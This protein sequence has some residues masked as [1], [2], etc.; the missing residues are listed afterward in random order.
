MLLEDPL[1]LLIAAAMVCVVL[2]LMIGVA[3]FAKGG[4][5]NRKYGNLLMRCRVGMQFVAVVLIVIFAYL[6]TK[7]GQ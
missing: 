5:F 3:G 7:G 6:R 1:F 2:I 4:E